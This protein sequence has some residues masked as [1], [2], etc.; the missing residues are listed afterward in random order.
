M[1]VNAHTHLELGGF[2]HL[3][4]P[5]EGS[6]F[7][8]WIQTLIAARH[9]IADDGLLPYQKAVEAG[10]AALRETGATTVGDISATGAS[11]EPL[12]DSGL[13]GV[14][15]LEVLGL[16]PTA[17]L[18]RLRETRAKIET[19][20]QRENSMRLGLTIHAPYSCHPDLFR[21]GAAW[22]VAENVP[23]CIHIAES[24]AETELLQH[25]TGDFIELKRALNLPDLP[26]PRR[27]PVAYLEDLGV[28]EAKPLLIHCVQVDE[29][30]IQR[31]A[32]SGS[33][34]V[35]CPRSNQRLQCGRMP[36]EKFLAAGVPV[37]LG[38]DSLT[39][40]PSLDIRE[41]A[42]A[43]IEM[44]ASLVPAEAISALLQSL[45]SNL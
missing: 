25:G 13:S 8:A 29:A 41:E 40:S 28:L 7:V 35:H 1:T 2:A 43:A 10:I 23:L 45:I 19:Y 37:A 24:K 34:V 30:D 26:I 16:E 18:Q 21:E 20:R 15:Y 12:L 14:V 9:T 4:P 32:R 3:L 6:P 17:A 11:V 27:S 38:T 42:E 44:H 39:S 33:A 36:L 31:L 5:P 22:C